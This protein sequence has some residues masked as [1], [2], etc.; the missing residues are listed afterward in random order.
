[1]V[2]PTKQPFTT[3]APPSDGEAS[4]GAGADEEV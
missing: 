4:K 2:P 3:Q 1:M